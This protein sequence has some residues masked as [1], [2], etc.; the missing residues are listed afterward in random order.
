MEKVVY[1]VRAVPDAAAG[2]LLREEL[3]ALA[4]SLDVHAATVLVHDTDASAAP[5]PAPSPGREVDYPWSTT[6]DEAKH[7]RS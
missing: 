2:D 1:L 6:W 7:L 5:S 3:L 4:R